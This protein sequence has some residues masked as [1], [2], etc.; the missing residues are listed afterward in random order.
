[1]TRSRLPA[2]LAEIADAAGVEAAWTIARAHGGTSVYFPRD[3]QPGHWLAELVGLEAARKICRQFSVGNTG[4]NVLIPLA[5]I[6]QQQERLVRALEAGQSAAQAAS[7]A[8][9]HERSAFRARKRLK[10][11]QGKKKKE[12]RPDDRQTKLL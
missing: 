10:A 1:M 6:G 9:M 4:V 2:V 11:A 12:R 8:G 7:A 3:A 5:R